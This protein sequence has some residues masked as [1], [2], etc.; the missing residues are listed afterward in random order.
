MDSFTV[1]LILSVLIVVSTVLCYAYYG[2]SVKEQ[3]DCPYAPPRRPRRR[4]RA[5]AVPAGASLAADT[6]IPEAG[7]THPP[8]QPVPRSTQWNFTPPTQDLT[9]KRIGGEKNLMEMGASAISDTMK[10]IQPKILKDDCCPEPG[11]CDMHTVWKSTF[12]GCPSF[13]VRTGTIEPGDP[14][15]CK[16]Y[17]LDRRLWQADLNPLIMER[18]ILSGKLWNPYEHMHARQ[19]FLQ[20]ISTDFSSRKDKYCRRINNLEETACKTPNDGAGVS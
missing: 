15:A 13:H 7:C 1:F 14:G 18:S 20:F 11:M 10:T 6:L 3:P 8:E 19:K 12:A 17:T 5:P 2:N 16:D 4:R 9:S